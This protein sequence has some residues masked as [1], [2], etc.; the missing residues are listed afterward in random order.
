MQSELGKSTWQAPSVQPLA[1]EGWAA[2]VREQLTRILTSSGFEAS[3]RSRRMLRHL[4]EDRH[5]SVHLG[6]KLHLMC[7]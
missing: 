5:H 4:V 2:E 7:G 3:E 1:G 6:A